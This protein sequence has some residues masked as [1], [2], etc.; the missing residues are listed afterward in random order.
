MT[1]YRHLAPALVRGGAT[2]H[3]LEGSGFCATDSRNRETIDG[4]TV[5]SLEAVR[6]ARWL[7][8]FVHLNAAPTCRRMLAA[9]WAAWEQAGE[10]RD[11]DVVEAADFGFLCLPPILQPRAPTVLQM[12][13]SFGQIQ[14]HDPAPGLELEGALALA[15]ETGAATI[16]SALQVSTLAAG[17]YWQRQSGRPAACLRRRVSSKAVDP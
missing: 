15:L 17:T 10:L 9:A 13:G 4:V 16:A 3:I 12:H 1:Y 6:L 7:E 5:E 8:A 14:R 2:V 11:F